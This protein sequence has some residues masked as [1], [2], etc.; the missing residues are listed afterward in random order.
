RR[1][2]TCAGNAF[3]EFVTTPSPKDDGFS[4]H[5]ELTPTFGSAGPVRARARMFLAAL[6]SRCS[7]KPQEQTCW[8][9]R[10]HFSTTWPQ[11]LH[12][13]LVPRAFTSTTTTPALSAL[14]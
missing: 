9:C 2:R 8:R 4:E 3:V 11:L 13:W 14:H 1:S 7:A 5:C 10:K 12:R 6:T